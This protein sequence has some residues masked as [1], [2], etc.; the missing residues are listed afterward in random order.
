M[1]NQYPPQGGR[2]LQANSYPTGNYPTGGY[3]PNSFPGG[4]PNNR[5][6]VNA[7]AGPRQPVGPVR[8]PGQ[9]SARSQFPPGGFQPPASPGHQPRLASRGFAPNAGQQSKLKQPKNAKKAKRA[10]LKRGL[11]VA[12]IIVV[13]LAI[14]AAFAVFTT[15]GRAAVVKLT[16]PRFSKLKD[17]TLPVTS[18]MSESFWPTSEYGAGKVT[19][20][21]IPGRW[22][23]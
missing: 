16:S 15:P 23:Q 5:P 8:N 11:L 7:P 2:P 9:Q 19:E 18:P 1:S 6:P 14:V 21:K 17:L 13:V 20:V 3:P 22:L 10:G 12:A 4:Y